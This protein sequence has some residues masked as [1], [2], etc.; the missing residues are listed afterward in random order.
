F[1]P[2]AGRT[3]RSH[4]AF[5]HRGSREEEHLRL[6]KFGG[7]ASWYVT[8]TDE[9]GKTRRVSTRTAVR[10][11]AEEFLRNFIAGTVA[12]PPPDRITINDACQYYL[13]GLGEKQRDRQKW[14]LQAICR[15]L[16]MLRVDEVT[17]HVCRGYQEARKKE[18]PGLSQ[19]TLR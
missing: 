7:R 6:T 16:G 9:Q 5:H 18:R 17:R 2:H 14:N 19:G 11:E 3:G 4:S 13:D 8:W 15:H 10:P 12:P 1:G